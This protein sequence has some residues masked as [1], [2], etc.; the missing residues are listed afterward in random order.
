MTNPMSFQ[1]DILPQFTERDIGAR[2]MAL[3][4]EDVK[5]HA[6]SSTIVSAASATL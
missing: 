2:R 5:A 6:A 4:Q 1:E 3:S